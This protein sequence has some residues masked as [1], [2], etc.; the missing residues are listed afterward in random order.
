ML[1]TASLPRLEK[2]WPS[3]HLGRML[4]PT[5]HSNLPRTIE[6]GMPFG[7]D[8][9]AFSGFKPG[10]FVNLLHKIEGMDC[11]FVACPD[12]FDPV[13]RKGDAAKTLAQFVRWEPFI[14]SFDLPVALV[15][16][17]GQEDHLVPWSK[18]EAL[19]VGGSTAWKV[20]EHAERL[21]KEAKRR[22]K[23]V[24]M[25]RVNDIFRM[26]DAKEW[27]VDSFDGSKYG[28]WSD[29]WIPIGLE[30]CSMLQPRMFARSA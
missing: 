29:T 21:V 10:R 2:F 15:L 1:V 30:M 14:H 20:G 7:V 27:G 24:H 6:I 18:L 13:A 3:E 25:G 12:V 8:N 4:V 17:D 23:Y 26:S 5:Q 9:G 16:Q 19:F 11:L 22:G 28:R